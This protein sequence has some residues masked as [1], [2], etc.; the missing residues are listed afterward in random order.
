MKTLDSERGLTTREAAELLGRTAGTLQH[1]RWK[2]CGPPFRK[3]Q[4][5]A[6]YRL[7]D[8]LAYRDRF[9]VE[10]AGRGR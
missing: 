8:V 4:G 5:R 3:V 2:R 6:V 9:V 1:W 10:T 7:G